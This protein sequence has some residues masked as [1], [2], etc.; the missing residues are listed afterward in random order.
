MIC[1]ELGVTPQVDPGTDVEDEL[2]IPASPPTDV[3]HVVVSLSVRPEM[4]NELEQVFVDVA[5]LPTIVTPVCDPD[6]AL[7]MTPAECPVIVAP[8]VSSYVIQPLLASSSAGP[9]VG[10]PGFSHPSTGSVGDLLGNRSSPVV[11]APEGFLLPHAA[12]LNQAQ[13]EAGLSFTGDL[14]G[15]LFPAI[16][17]TPVPATAGGPDLSREG[18]FDIHQDNPCSAASPQLLPDTQGCLFRMTSYD[19]GTGG[20]IFAPAYGVQL[21]D[22]RLLEYVGAPESARLSRSPEYWVQHMGREKAATTQCG[23]HPFECPSPAAVGDS[24]KPNCVGRSAGSPRSSAISGRN[25]MMVF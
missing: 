4:D 5:S 8:G 18:P 22:P 1:P 17:L 15:G 21:H 20:P 16:P 23:T 6:G 14:S 24:T 11:S 13:P 12:E 25:E 10:S 9:D 3:D 2:S 7:R 19:E